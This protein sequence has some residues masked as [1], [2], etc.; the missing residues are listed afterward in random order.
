MSLL[1]S[2]ANNTLIINSS[3]CVSQSAN[4]PL[5]T[6]GLWSQS[7]ADV[8]ADNTKTVSAAH[9][10]SVWDANYTALLRMNGSGQFF[11]ERMTLH[12]TSN[13]A[14][15]FLDYL[16]MAISTSYAVTFPG[17]A[18]YTLDTGFVSPNESIV[19]V[20]KSADRIIS[21]RSTAPSPSSTGRM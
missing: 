4:C 12:P 17:G 18:G 19:C 6:P 1:P 8:V 21:F 5:P 20:K 7:G 16:V 3:A 15:D 13:S 9:A 10:P 2:L 14:S 11:S